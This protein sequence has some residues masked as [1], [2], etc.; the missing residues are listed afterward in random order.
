MTIR[1][2]AKAAKEANP[3]A[4]NFQCSK[5]C[6]KCGGT[7]RYIAGGHDCVYCQYQIAKRTNARRCKGKSQSQSAAAVKR[8]SQARLA[9]AMNYCINMHITLSKSA[10]LAQVSYRRLKQE[11]QRQGIDI[12]LCKS[13]SRAV[14][15]V[16]G[17]NTSIYGFGSSGTM[18]NDEFKAA[19]PAIKAMSLFD[20][21]YRKHR[22]QEAA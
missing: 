6:V 16:S 9:K 21:S 18:M 5:P 1:A 10:K 15:K 20:A 12:E 7:K 11:L 22:Q 14:M 19:A 17:N 4:V 13:A 3:S 8:E 2:E